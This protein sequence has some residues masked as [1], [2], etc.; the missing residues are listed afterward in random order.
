MEHREVNCRV[1]SN[2]NSAESF[3]HAGSA[4]M[5][6]ADEART[7]V[8]S[9]M[10]SIFHG[11]NYQHLGPTEAQNAREMDMHNYNTILASLTLMHDLGLHIGLLGLTAK[12]KA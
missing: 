4:L 3:H 8:V 7:A 11:R 9:N 12:E 5:I 1:H 6:A 10:T 2:G